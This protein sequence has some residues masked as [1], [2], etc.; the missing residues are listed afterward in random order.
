[1]ST[2]R[3][4]NVCAK[5][6]RRPHTLPQG[7]MVLRAGCWLQRLCVYLVLYFRNT[8]RVLHEWVANALGGLLRALTPDVACSDESL[9]TAVTLGT[10]SRG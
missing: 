6:R 10:A 3:N 1:M 8:T 7:A 2:G 4:R 9:V 5:H